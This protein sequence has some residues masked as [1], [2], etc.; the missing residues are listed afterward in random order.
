[1][2]IAYLALVVFLVIWIGR[3]TSDF[4]SFS[5]YWGIF[6]TLIGV[7]TGAIP[8]F[9]FKAKADEEQATAEKAEAKADEAAKQAETANEK[10]LAYAEALDPAAAQEIGR[11]FS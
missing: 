2:G 1:M 10:A 6:G 3:E 9:F 7:T 5:Q 11:R 4:E 8:S